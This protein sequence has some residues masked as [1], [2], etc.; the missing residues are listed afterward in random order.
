[1]TESTP[2]PLG[3]RILRAWREHAGL[4]SADLARA[5]PV[6]RAAVSNWESGTRG[7][8]TAA[9]I[10]IVEKISEGLRLSSLHRA[11]LLT[12]W[13]A[14]GSPAAL[15]P[16]VE[17]SH[18][19]Q[20]PSG[21]VWAWLRVRPGQ[22]HVVAALWWGEPLQGHVDTDAPPDG[23]LIQFPTSV[24]NP[25]LQITLEQPG[26]VDFGRGSIPAEVA[27]K[28][29]VP[30]LKATD[31][32]TDRIPFEAPLPARDERLLRPWFRRARALAEDY[33]LKWSLVVPH[34]GYARSDRA[35]QALDGSGLEISAWPGTVDVD[36]D[37]LIISQL[38]MSPEQVHQL[39]DARGLSRVGA[40][41]RVTRLDPLRPVSH[42]AIESLEASGRVPSES[43][44]IMRMDMVYGADGRLGVD[45]TFNS[46]SPV[47]G[48]ARQ[49]E[50]RFPSYW[51]GPVWLQ[52]LGAAPGESGLVELTW[53]LWRRRQ[54]V[55]SGAVVTTRKAVIDG[56]PLRVRLPDG[57]DV[58]AGAGVMPTALDI[59]RGWYPASISAAITLLR[60]GVAAVRRAREQSSSG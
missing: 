30:L 3:A 41:E 38:R 36:D 45:R 32:V 29:G 15:P 28:I 19:Y 20:P 6:E 22:T 46:R 53:G 37:G 44:V 51:N 24:P 58:V 59:N 43:K 48:R 2:P 13:Q 35:P 25:P 40:A 49:H 47:H 33:G 11:G 39:R 55:R 52:V 60:E 7:R 14:A 21:P 31:L 54:R 34:L 27:D 17:W 50:I 4:S 16:R 5:V 8:K 26:W 23:V 42:K 56:P 12:L 57:W 1:V 10:D 18:N 9:S